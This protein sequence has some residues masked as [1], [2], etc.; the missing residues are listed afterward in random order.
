MCVVVHGIPSRRGPDTDLDR[1]MASS[2]VRRSAAA[3]VLTF[4]SWQP[5]SGDRRIG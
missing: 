1:N 2:T 3:C 4:L 5:L